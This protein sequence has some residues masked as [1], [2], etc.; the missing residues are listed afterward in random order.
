[1]R[2]TK[3]C[4]YDPELNPAYQQLAA[5]YDIAVM[6]AR[7]YK[8]KDKA[9]VEVG[10]QIIERWILAKLRHLTFFSL[11]EL[12]QCIQSLLQGVNAK[13]FKQL[14]GSRQ[15]WFEQLDKPA[16]NPL[17]KHAY[18]FVDIKT[19]RVNVDY[20]IQY[21]QHLYSVP[22]QLVGE[23]VEI[24]ASDKLLAIFFHSRQVVSHVR[25]RHPGTSTE[26]GH[27]PKKHAKHQQWTP[28]RLLNWAKEIGPDVLEWVKTQL[29]LKAHPEQAYRVCLGLLN[30][31]KTYPTQRLNKACAIANQQ[32]L[33]KLK[34]IKALL[35][36]NQDKLPKDYSSDALSLPQDHENIRG[37]ENFH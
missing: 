9:K 19:A 35:Q 3:A 13:P 10:V 8:P 4:R 30:L 7:P 33:Y 32:K 23:K 37:P 17:P 5:H 2:V 11:A 24:H 28:G 14:T 6:P 20:H 29:Q 18:E 16:L 34:Q 15:Q 27:M 12:N 22:H 36:S 1:M 25:K 26:P 21:Q 31:S